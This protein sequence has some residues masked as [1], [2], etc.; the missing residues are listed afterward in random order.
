MT[1]RARSLLPSGADE[2]TAR[3]YLVRGHR[4]MLDH[5]LAGIYGVSTTRL[6]EQVKRNLKRFPP[7]FMFR[8]SRR[9]MADWISQFATSNPWVKM[10]LRRPP[11]AFTEHGA[12]MLATILNT[13]TAVRASILVVQAFVRLREVLA[14]NKALA[15]KFEELERRVG[16]H[17]KRIDELFEAIRQLMQHEPDDDGKP[18][19]KLRVEGFRRRPR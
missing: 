8:L 13:P 19:L 2:L 7:G 4:V 5:D 15:A 16:H 11:R 9:E 12:V 3:V 6:N 17:D 18:L 10:G 14:T 1:S